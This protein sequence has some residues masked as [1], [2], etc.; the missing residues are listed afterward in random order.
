MYAARAVQ[1]L[2]RWLEAL[3]APKVVRNDARLSLIAYFSG[4]GAD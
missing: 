1:T 4:L 2:S 3:G